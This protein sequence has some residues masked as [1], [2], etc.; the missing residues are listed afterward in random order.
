LASQSLKTDKY[1]IMELTILAHVLSIA[2]QTEYYSLL[3]PDLTFTINLQVD[4][5]NWTASWAY[6]EVVNQKIQ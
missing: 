4:S 5:I 6:N 3:C 2:Q 1:K